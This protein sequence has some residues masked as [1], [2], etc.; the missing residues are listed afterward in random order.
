M[1]NL[2]SW[3]KKFAIVL[4]ILSVI[5]IYSI[6]SLLKPEETLPVY[7]PDMV[8]A[9]LVDSTVRYVRK[10]HTVKDFELINQNGDT[11]TQDYYKDKIYVADFFFT[12]CLTICPVMTDHMLK[13]QEKIKDDP[14][15]LLLSH[16]VFPKTDS[17][18]V[19]KAYA[20]EK[21]VMDKKWNLV[22]GDKK[23]IYELAR[24]SYLASK[25]NGD[26]GPY[27]MIHTENFVLVDK[28]KRIRGFYDGTDA[29]A[30][31]NLMHDIKVLKREYR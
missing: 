7:Q 26:G 8:N 21:G 10:Y 12:T 9:E 6:Y 15:V 24:K 3:L 18:P 13:I 29:E 14:E 25:S 20:E 5:I 17:V 19:L 2:F 22:T 30:I 31:E 23:H 16:T 27:D 28:E 1:R 4:F 11:I